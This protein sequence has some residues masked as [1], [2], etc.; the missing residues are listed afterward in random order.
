MG[1]W[2][3]RTSQKSGPDYVIFICPPPDGACGFMGKGIPIHIKVLPLD[4]FVKQCVVH[5]F[6]ICLLCLQSVL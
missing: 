2:V 4:D 3:V 5:L 1:S 6:F